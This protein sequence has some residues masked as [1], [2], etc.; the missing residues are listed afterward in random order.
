MPESTQWREALTPPYAFNPG[1]AIRQ[2]FGIADSD[3]IDLI[4]R[5]IADESK[6]MGHGR[7]R[8][9]LCRALKHV[10]LSSGQRRRISDAVGRRL[11][12]GKFSEHFF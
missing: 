8:A 6:G 4:I 5:F 7:L 1:H 12:S 9:R 2:G 11:L 3:D 10:S